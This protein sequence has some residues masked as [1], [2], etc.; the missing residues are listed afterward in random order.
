MANE[1]FG[2]VSNERIEAAVDGTIRLYAQ[3][4]GALLGSLA[5]MA[6]EETFCTC[7]TG[8]EGSI[9]HHLSAIHA[10]LKADVLHRAEKRLGKPSQ[11][12]ATNHVFP[13]LSRPRH[14]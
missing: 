13:R 5:W 9:E 14:G 10:A 1:L 3:R 6:V 4:G 12:G 2:A 8:V 11:T 7:V